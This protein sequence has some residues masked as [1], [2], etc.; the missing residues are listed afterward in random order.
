M[1]NLNQVIEN[2]QL[3]NAHAKKILKTSNKSHE[4]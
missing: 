1:N 3:N 2:K 4:L